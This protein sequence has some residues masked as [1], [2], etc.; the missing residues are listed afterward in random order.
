MMTKLG[1]ISACFLAVSAHAAETV[2]TDIQMPGTQPEDAVPLEATGRCSNCHSGYNNAGTIGEP[3]HEPFTGWLGAAMGNAGRDPIFWATLAISEQDFD[4]SGDLC[5]RCHST[6]GWYGGNSEPTDGSGLAV[7]DDEGVDCDACHLMANPDGTEY[8]GVMVAPFIANCGDDFIAPAGTCQSSAEGYYG[9]GMLSLW[10][11]GKFGPYLVTVARHDYTQSY[12]QRDVDYCGSCHDVSNPAVGDLAPNHGAQYGAPSVVA[13]GVLGGP[14]ADKAA[15]NNPPYAYGV[16]ERTFSEYKASAFP[17]TRVGDFDTLPADLKTVGGSIHVT[18]QA[19]LLAASEAEEHGGIAG[20]YADGAPRYFSCQSCHMRP[21]LSAGADK[22][23]AEVREDLPSHDHT[24]GNYW[25]ADIVRYQDS[26]GMLRLGGGLTAEQVVAMELGQQ[27]AMDHLHQAASLQLDGDTLKVINLTGHKLISGYPEG[28]R[29][30][31]NVKWYDP[32]DV[33]L[34]EDGAYGPI[35]A[36]VSNP[37]GGPDIPVESILDLDGGN[38]RIYEAH[39]AITRDWAATIEALHGPDFALNYDRQSG[40]VVCTVGEF[41]LADEDP[42]KKDA[43]KGDYIDTFHF[44]LNNYVSLDNRIPPYGMNYDTARMR[45]TLPS[46]ADQYGGGTPG[47]TYRYWDEITLDPPVGAD[48]ADIELL[49]QGTNWE[50]IQFLYLANDG[51]NAFLGQEGVNMLDAW[52][53]AVTSMDPQSRTMV[54]PMVMTSTQWTGGSVNAAPTCSIDS[55]P[56]DV[57]IETGDSIDFAGTATDSDGTIASHAW[58]F[59]GGIPASASVEDPGLV[60]Y[61][62]VGVFAV[63]FSAEDDEGAVCSEATLTVTVLEHDTYTVGG[64][65]SGLL[66]SGL[67]LQNNTG[68]DLAIDINGAFTFGTALVEGSSYDV[69]V[70]TQ[71]SAPN[72]ICTVSNGSG[73]IGESSITNVLVNCVTETYTIGGNVSGLSGSGLVLRNNGADDL[74]IG[75]DGGFVFPIP[76]DDGS[77]YAVSVLS[78]PTNPN[79]TCTVSGGDGVLSGA[80]IIDVSITCKL[81]CIVN[82]VSDTTASSPVSYEACET[83]VVGPGFLGE[84]GASVTLSSGSEVQF[85]PDFLIQTGASL[86]VKVCGQSL[87]QAGALPMPYGCHSCVDQICDANPGCCNDEYTQACVDQVGAI[88]NLACE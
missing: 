66:G 1:F 67:V 56:G 64:D 3:Q 21:V 27:R 82:T 62:T 37:S 29:M 53:N 60:T 7:E 10:E 63:S 84:A 72:Q 54:A 16:V 36:T 20:D 59:A 31:I 2:P 39:Y 52:L 50:Y 11:G 19:A 76:L 4:G 23:D 35:G 85:T 68:D 73:T 8:A 41:L 51:Q 17:T 86:D 12:F 32:D 25:F 43:C 70:L 87:C 80:N 74:A 18:Y 46:P 65:V 71:P 69:T 15:F 38:T 55:P 13:S 14:V 6:G 48:H 78:H 49:Y 45:N 42:A 81:H 28:R 75:A 26:R 79:Q 61:G 30:W 33:L 22:K 77:G 9:S 58:S 40:A 83:L 88:C 44:A 57:E 34:R 5:L 24:G 47:S